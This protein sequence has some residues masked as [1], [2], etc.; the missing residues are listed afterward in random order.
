MNLQEFLTYLN[1]GKTVVA[2]SKE[3]RYMCALS[4]EALRLTA[5]L[6]NTY[7]TPEEIRGI[8][9]ELTGKTIDETFALFPP[10]Y[11]DCG[12]NL[13]IGKNVFLNSGCKFQ[14]Q[15]GIEIGDGVLIGHNVVLATL[16][17]G[18][19]QEE[20]HDLIPA[21]IRIGKNVWI[22]SNSTILPGVTIGD[23]AIVAAGA[24]VT[25]DV[26]KNTVVGGVPA[27]VLRTIGGEA[28]SLAISGQKP[29]E[30]TQDS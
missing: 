9:A 27:K 10:F 7:H 25:K 21:P 11:T 17:H 6:N 29:A 2:G 22:G 14:D 23:G 13:T 5:K 26:P 8:F 18:F 3:H 20:R 19:S 24:V 30:I 16:N 4:Q 15:G 12:K 1:S 28:D